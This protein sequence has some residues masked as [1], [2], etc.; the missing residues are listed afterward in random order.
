ML[1]KRL[2]ALTLF[3]ALAA[4]H[5]DELRAQWVQTN[6]PYGQPVYCFAVS[7]MNLFAGT[8]SG[9]YRSTDNGISWSAAN[10]G[11]PVGKV[12]ALFAFGAKLFAGSE[13]TRHTIYRSSNNGMSWEV[14]DSGV[15]GVST[16]VG[17]AECRSNLF[18]E[19]WSGVYRSTD[20]GTNWTAADSGLTGFLTVFTACNGN[21]FTG[22]SYSNPSGLFRSTDQGASWKQLLTN[23]DGYPLEV[24]GL[25]VIG[26]NI[27]ATT[28]SGILLS[29]DNGNSWDTITTGVENND[30]GP[31]VAC[32]TML[33]ATTGLSLPG[34]SDVIRSMDSGATWSDSRASVFELYAVAMIDTNIFAGTTCGVF[35]S[36]DSGATWSLNN[37]GLMRFAVGRL[38]SNGSSLFAGT[39]GGVF[40][41]TDAG[42]S[43]T[44]LNSGL[45]QPYITDF[46]TS[47]S[48]LF[49]GVAYS[50]VFLLTD[51]GTTW[52]Q[53]LGNDVHTL[54]R[55]GTDLFA[56][57]S[58]GVFRSTDS[59]SAWTEADN[60]LGID[61]YVSNLQ[62]IGTDLF[63]TTDTLL[64][65]GG[66][67]NG[68]FRSNDSGGS[69]TEI[70][71][72]FASDFVTIGTMSFL[73]TKYGVL[74]SIDNG[75]NWS[76]A[77]ITD[78]AY[79]GTGAFAVFGTNLFVSAYPGVLLTTDYGAS[80][81]NVNS[82]LTSRVS[83]FASDSIYLFA[84]TVKGD[85]WRRPL[86]EMISSSAVLE[87][88][89]VKQDIYSFPNPFSQST[90]ITFT[91]QAAGYADVSIVNLLGAE[92]A[93]LFSGE[94][95]AGEHSFAWSNPG[96]PDGMYECLVRMNGRVETLPVVLAR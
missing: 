91:S 55:I 84:L 93:H 68:V 21:L 83:S 66:S 90:N 4:M 60:G 69:W 22:G 79:P 38:M 30:I 71:S 52:R 61:Y 89:P 3:T 95:A 9:V 75:K 37:A 43:W 78:S 45:I 26:T 49:A 40:R 74:R 56:G 51:S 50:G 81:K 15:P 18:V 64:L 2:L 27:F 65:S 67:R 20:S 29:K 70:D 35:R 44:P 53:L 85:A 28:A 54:A 88:P 59:G 82:G 8:D 17:F 10:N 25:A 96:L 73:S 62:A 16:I 23:R 39:L 77:A 46:L 47:G 76:S 86:S 72:E 58:Q 31:L 87:S 34:G 57:T 1:P 80:W 5:A 63:A 12:E 7:G 42:E 41:S 14:S 92:V 94:L 32:G 36:T 24:V 13:N 19:T 48:N 33:F 11:Y 6:G